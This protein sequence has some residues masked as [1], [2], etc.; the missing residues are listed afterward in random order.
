[1]FPVHGVTASSEASPTS[2]P[3]NATEVSFS[4]G[5]L[6]IQSYWAR[7]SRV[8][9]SP[10]PMD[11][12]ERS[13]RISSEQTPDRDQF[14]PGLWPCR[15]PVRFPQHAAALAHA[16]TSA[17]ESRQTVRIRTKYGN[18]LE[19]RVMVAR[20]EAQT[21]DLGYIVGCTGREAKG[22]SGLVKGAPEMSVAPPSGQDRIMIYG[23][24]S[25]GT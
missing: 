11:K 14:H 4:T 12:V 24:K 18:Q 5:Y 7:S 1:M 22:R 13:A 3:A 9:R 23:P 19:K 16:D 2:V 8:R 21:A 17:K 6:N 10:T 15:S 20:G 25:D